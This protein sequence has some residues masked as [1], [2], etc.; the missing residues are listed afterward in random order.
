MPPPLVMFT[1][2]ASGPPDPWPGFAGP[3]TCLDFNSTATAEGVS[4]N[5]NTNLNFA[6]AW[7]MEMWFKVRAA[8]GYM[9][10]VKPTGTNN[11]R[12]NVN[13]T[14]S[15]GGYVA[16]IQLHDTTGG[17]AKKQIDFDN[18][19]T[20]L[21]FNTWYHFVLTWNGTDLKG[22][23]NGTED[24]GFVSGANDAATMANDVRGIS[25]GSNLGVA[26]FLLNGLI[27]SVAIW[28]VV[29]GASAVTKLYNGGNARNRDLAQD[30]GNY[31]SAANLQHWWLYGRT[32]VPPESN[33]GIN[34]GLMGAPNVM[35]NAFNIT[36][37]D[38]LVSDYPA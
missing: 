8:G 30:S 29:L 18:Q 25:H 21:A 3:T 31:T 4:K 37:A 38:D 34:Y 19:G 15:G 28:N 9:V 11:S 35:D 7:S 5:G 36:A 2:K 33:M 24:A 22:Y 32:A 13:A 20:V 1:A 6:N 17:V 14:A 10:L 26:A 16:R 12:L 23:V 27:Y